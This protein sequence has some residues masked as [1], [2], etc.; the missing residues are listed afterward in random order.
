MDPRTFKARLATD[1]ARVEAVLDSRL[2]KPSG[3]QAVVQEAMRYSALAGGKRL[4]PF[5]VIESARLFGVEGDGPV[6]AGAALECVHAYSL[7]HDDLPCMDDDD[8]RRGKPTVHKVW[9]EAI[10]VLAGDGLLTYAFELIADA[11]V[12]NDAEVRLALSRELAVASGTLGMIGGQVVDMTVAEDARTAE[13]IESLQD[14]KTGALIRFGAR[15]G[16]HLGAASDADR[17]HMD[18]YARALGLLFQITDD[19]L[20][21]EGC[22]DAVGKAVGKDAELG[23]ATFVS[24]LGLDKAKVMAR[25][26]A[27]E[28]KHHLDGFG[29]R[30]D[31]LR[32]CVDFV[33]HRDR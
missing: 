25:N 28:A 23:K 30:G 8:L 3:D 9:D 12:H 31:V 13:I 33:L 27:D 6:V 19:I 15:A 32:A 14:M 29:E 4:R 17:A 21:V 10:A 2:P 7:I 26:M 1:A 24:L 5:L 18:A 11:D 22:A 20:D 16:A